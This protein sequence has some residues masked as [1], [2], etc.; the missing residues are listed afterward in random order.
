MA[1]DS[2]VD[3]YYDTLALTLVAILGSVIYP[4]MGPPPPFRISRLF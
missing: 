4:L 3:G 1:L 2:I